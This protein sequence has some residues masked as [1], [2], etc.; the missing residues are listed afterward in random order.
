MLS[1]PK[2]R[3]DLVASPMDIDGEAVVVVKDPITGRF[4]K[5]RDPEYWLISQLDGARS[6]EQ[7]AE[8][9]REKFNLNITADNVRDFIG[10]LEANFFL[11][12]SRSE[13]EISRA[14]KQAGQTGS[15]FG[16]LLFIRLK[17]FAPGRLLNRLVD[18]YRPFHN[19]RMWSLQAALVLCG[20][21]IVAAHPRA[22][23]AFNPT[24][25]FTIGSI[26]AIM[27]SLFVIIVFHEFAHA[28][29]CR[30]YGGEVRE[31]GFLLM[32]FQPCFYCDVSDAWLF[33]RKSQRMAVTL[34][35]PWFQLVLTALAAL[36]WRL[37]VPGT[38]VNEIARLIALVSLVSYFF[39]FN[40]LIKLDGYYLLSDYLE[41]PNLRS[42]AFGYFGNLLRRRL[43]GWAIPIVEVRP[44]ERKIFLIYGVLA[45]IYSSFL[46]GLVLFWVAR[47]LI[48]N[49]GGVGLLLLAVTLFLILRRNVASLGRG[50]VTHISYMKNLRSQPLR[51]TVY[52]AI[53]IIVIV[54]LFFIPVPDRVSGDI[55]VRPIAEFKIS[56]NEFG[57]IERSIREG[58][59]SPDHKVSILQVNTSE[60]GVLDLVPTVNDGQVVTQGDTLAVLASNQTTQEIE[61]AEAELQRL[62]STLDLL[63]APPKLEEVHEAESRVVSAKAN[64]DKK[65]SDYERAKGLADKHL[66]S[67]QEIENANSEMEI[68]MAD[69]RTEQSAL[70]LIKSPP[71]PEEETVLERSIQKQRARLGF[72]RSQVDAQSILAPF[73]G[74]VARNS[75][76]EAVL[77]VINSR[78]VEL[79]VP[80]NDFDIT[81]VQLKQLVTVKVRSYP[82]RILKGLV[83]RIPET[84][85]TIDTEQRFE[86]AVL[87]DNSDGLL[88]DGMTGYA[89]IEIGTASI[90][91]L[92]FRAA[93]SRV[94][95]EFWSW[96]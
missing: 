6:P 5:L 36:I 14:S 55:V 30:H 1:F 60:M 68:A 74:I 40:P 84:A 72:L 16:R 38:L 45:M 25:L 89:K 50:L 53:T 3:S 71:R 77:S 82:G 58:G 43:L 87:V 88:R 2:L 69:W 20:L 86:V 49:Y 63:R 18:F 34:A 78:R 8:Q 96:W 35:G 94:R 75:N 62:E 85:S 26:S 90:A 83:V 17:A 92:V 52:I 39:N 91:R 81:R 64:F 47:W 33:P 57:L 7:V 59:P 12:D 15:L 21:Y 27:I 61:S 66:I 11:E 41:I 70:D 48:D 54:G 10:L 42:R 44:R 4:F 29:V 73:S 13:Q 28:V 79:L 46:V 22:F 23:A 65:K 80:V 32:Y 31:M 24:E 19:G 56:M 93:L 67:H 37:T 51:L 76:Q 9:F 95:V